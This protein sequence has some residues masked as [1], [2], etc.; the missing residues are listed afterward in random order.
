VRV[1]TELIITLA[2]IVQW[3][4]GCVEWCVF[5]LRKVGAFCYS[6]VSELEMGSVITNGVLGLENCLTLRW[7]KGFFS[8]WAYKHRVC[9][10]R[11]TAVWVYCVFYFCGSEFLCHDV[12]HKRRPHDDYDYIVNSG[13]TWEYLNK[14]VNSGNTWE[15]LNKLVNSGNTWE[16]Q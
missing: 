12:G 15:Y 10:G 1:H 14:L 6:N 5:S 8:C 9:D 4:A 11:W 7:G 13:N 2:F 16:S 3:A